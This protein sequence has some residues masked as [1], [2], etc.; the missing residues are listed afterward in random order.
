MSRCLQKPISIGYP[1][2]AVLHRNEG[3]WRRI[4]ADIFVDKVQ[5]VSVRR[6]VVYEIPRLPGFEAARQQE[7][8]RGTTHRR[9]NQDSQNPQDLC[10]V[11]AL[12][13]C[14]T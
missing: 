4:F 6:Y 13:A 7:F 14:L 12:S 10:Q 8:L 9:G 5:F 2:R 11:A 1:A 3:L